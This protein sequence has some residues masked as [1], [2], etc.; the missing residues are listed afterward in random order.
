MKRLSFLAVVMAMLL[1]RRRAQ[2]QE[3]IIIT[4]AGPPTFGP[5]SSWPNGLCGCCGR[6]DADPIPPDGPERRTVECGWCH[7]LFV[8]RK[9]QQ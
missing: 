5:P 4:P 1:G 6:W 3:P 8:Q 9:E 7:V 2:A